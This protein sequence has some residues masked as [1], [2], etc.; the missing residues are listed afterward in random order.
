MMM[1]R[2]GRRD[3][4]RR[5]RRPLRR[6]HAGAEWLRLL[7]LLLLKKS[8]RRELAPAR[9]RYADEALIGG[10]LRGDIGSTADPTDA[11]VRDGQR[12]SGR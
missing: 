9:G 2:L 8:A 11:A 3:R 5:R 4:R 10:F 12:G 7:L 6:W 1:R